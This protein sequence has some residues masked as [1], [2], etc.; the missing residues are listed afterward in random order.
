M[1]LLLDRVRAKCV[2]DGDCW[3]W[4][5]ATQTRR[6]VTPVMKWEGKCRIVRQLLVLAKGI[7]PT[8]KVCTYKCGNPLCVNPDHLE[9]ITKRKMGKRVNAM[10]KPNTNAMF[11]AKMAKAMRSRSKLT[12]EMVEQIRNAEGSQ[13]EICERFNVSQ[14]TISDIKRGRTWRDY[15]NPFTQ[16]MG[17]M[18]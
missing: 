11:R 6:R 8:G 15:S 4:K 12:P 13:Y 9:V 7:D 17:R 1:S 10:M 2:E 5:G 3:E 16:L 14:Q 18:R